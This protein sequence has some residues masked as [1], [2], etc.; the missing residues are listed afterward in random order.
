MLAKGHSIVQMID[1]L[2]PSRLAMP[3]DP[4][5]LQLGSLNREIKRALVT[6]DVTEEV[7]D[8][9]IAIG[10]NLIIAHHALIYRPLK[11]IRTDT[12][13]GRI[14]E[15]CIQN[16]IAIYIAHTNLDIA[17]GG[18]ND[19]MADALNLKNVR[20]LSEIHQDAIYKLVVYVPEADHD[21]VR[22]ALFDAGAGKIGQYSHCSFNLEGTG[23]FLPGEGTNPHIGTQGKLEN[24]HEVRVETV[25]PEP[26]LDRVI[27]AMKRAHPYEEP[28]FDIYRLYIDGARYGLGRIGTLERPV[29]LQQLATTVR[30]VFAM[31]GVRIVGDMQK[32]VSKVAVMGGAGSK[33]MYDAV[34]NGADVYITGDVDFHT[35]QDA[36][37]AGICLIDAGH[38]AEH[39]MKEHV[40]QYLSK[41]MKKM[42]WDTEIVASQVNTNPFQSI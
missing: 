15:K 36:L 10:A 1:Q 34:R 13:V 22:Q 35:A 26:L 5:G 18:I 31:N 38:Y 29:T 20:F 25:V 17:E 14:I 42:K 33:Y 21:R 2:A 7:V 24:V 12:P 28:A 9:A 19:M 39:I 11:N 41:Q 40:V 23:T 4:I 6:L 27:S 32:Q 8:E 30:D 37:S 16:Q 3:N